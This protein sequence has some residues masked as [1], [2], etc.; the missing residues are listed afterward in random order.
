MEKRST[1]K[2]MA[3][4][5]VVTAVVP[6]S[7]LKP[8]V[9]SVVL[10]AHAQTSSQLISLNGSLDVTGQED[11][12]QF[13]INNCDPADV[14]TISLICSDG[15]LDPVVEAV[16]PNGT[17]FFDD[18]GGAACDNFSSSLIM[19]VPAVN[20]DWAVTARGFGGD[21]GP[22]TLELTVTGNCNI[23]QI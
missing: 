17:E 13:R 21:T 4:A 18:D 20:G 11:N 14:I 8:I 5:S 23:I 3:G 2:K 19:E 6:S 1:L 22:Y 16:D 10:P 12:F 7:W 9:S 15:T